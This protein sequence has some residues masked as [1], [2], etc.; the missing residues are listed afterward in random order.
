MNWIPE[1]PERL[2]PRR[3]GHKFTLAANMYVVRIA[4][5]DM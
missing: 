1:L 4:D 3:A 5:A 2:I